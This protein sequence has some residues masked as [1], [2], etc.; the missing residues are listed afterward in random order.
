MTR[1]VLA[2]ADLVATPH[3]A[4]HPAVVETAHLAQRV[5]HK[6]PPDA[7]R[8]AALGRLL[9]HARAD[10]AD[11]P[12]ELP[13][14]VDLVAP[15]AH[16]D[17][18][19]ARALKAIPKPKGHED[20]DGAEPARTSTTV[21][22]RAQDTETWHATTV[23][24]AAAWPEA[25]AEL[26]EILV[27]IAL[28]HGAAIDGFTDFSV[29]GAVFVRRDRLEPGADGLPGPVRLAE[30]LVHEGTHTRCNAASVADEPFLRP[31]EG[32]GPLVATPLRADPR[33]LTGLFQ[34]AVVLARSVL[35]YR[36]VLDT[37]TGVGGNAG[38][39]AGG[40]RATA[41]IRA[42]LEQLERSA[43]QAA[44]TL[45]E[46]RHALTDHGLA[47]LDQVAPVVEATRVRG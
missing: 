6:D 30:A 46:H 22:W 36:R 19:V 32:D 20:G 45:V 25:N 3:E 28:L 15:R 18:S 9:D 11:P 1:S 16:L 21:A 43:T 17:R 24:L 40:T 29:H 33:P 4:T 13:W 39:G 8:L 42:R 34:Q 31:A 41:A 7:Q 10:I 14:P 23:L 5:L 26:R 27:Q 47:V 2:R 35:L 37:G 12:A 44:G 38:T